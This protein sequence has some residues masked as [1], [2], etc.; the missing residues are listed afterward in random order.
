MTAQVPLFGTDA[1]AVDGEQL[2]ALICSRLTMVTLE[3]RRTGQRR[4]FKVEA[5][6]PHA[7][8]GAEAA[9]HVVS[10]LHGPNNTGDYNRLGIVFDGQ[11]W[12]HGSTFSRPW[13]DAIGVDTVTHR[14][15]QFFWERLVRRGDVASTMAVYV[16]RR[17]TVCGRWLTVPESVVS[18]LGPVCATKTGS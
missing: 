2:R 8:A 10:W 17:C 12:R 11:Q 1:L 15:W 18:G 5:I 4:T 16:A 14:A 6:Q 3:S 7:S 9:R 13:D